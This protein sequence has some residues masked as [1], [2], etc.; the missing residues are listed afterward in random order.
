MLRSRRA[1]G[2]HKGRQIQVNLQQTQSKA[3]TFL[4]LSPAIILTALTFFLVYYNYRLAESS[5]KQ[6]WLTERSIKL[7]E[8]NFAFAKKSLTIESRPYIWVHKFE[9]VEYSVGKKFKVRVFLTNFGKTPALN[10]TGNISIKSFSGDFPEEP[11]YY[12][13]DT[14]QILTKTVMPPQKVIY[15]DVETAVSVNLE[16]KSRIEQR[17]LKIYVY[18]KMEYNSNFETKHTTTFCA[19]YD[20]KRKGFTYNDKH[21][22]D[23]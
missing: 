8:D 18:G 4:R 16:M 13:T 9:L 22:D 5:S 11:E 14:L 10:A 19:F 21:N 3:L 6:A 2:R 17:G 7:A 1:L 12:I 20:P 15:V 23:Y